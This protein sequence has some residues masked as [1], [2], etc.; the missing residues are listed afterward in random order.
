M[1]RMRN[2]NN[3]HHKYVHENEDNDNV[4]KRMRNKKNCKMKIWTRATRA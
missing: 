4:D 3:Y 1:D 2:N